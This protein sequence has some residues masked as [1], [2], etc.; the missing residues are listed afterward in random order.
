[1]GLLRQGV[2]AVTVVVHEQGAKSSLLV[3]KLGMG[4]IPHRQG[5][6]GFLGARGGG[7]QALVEVLC[8]PHSGM[9]QWW[10]VPCACRST[11]GS[12]LRGASVGARCPLPAARIPYLLPEDGVR[13]VGLCCSW[14]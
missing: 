4:Q 8:R 6:L 13:G 5:C 12:F 10:P 1:M 14:A 7:A 3:R 11:V 2:Q 9:V